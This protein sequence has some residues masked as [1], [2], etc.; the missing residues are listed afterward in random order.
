MKTR[1]LGHSGLVVFAIGLGCMGMSAN[2]GPP[3]D[4]FIRTRSIRVRSGTAPM[5]RMPLAVSP[6]E[7]EI[8]LRAVAGVR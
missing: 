7:L 8:G 1:E 2:Y 6:P 5:P 3:V 4:K